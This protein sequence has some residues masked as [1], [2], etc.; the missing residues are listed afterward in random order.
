MIPTVE[1]ETEYVWRTIR[2]I[3]FFEE[4]NYPVSL[5]P[6]E[7][8]ESLKEKSKAGTFGEED[9][10]ELFRYMNAKVYNEK[11]YQ[12]GKKKIE[13]QKDLV[14]KMANQIIQSKKKWLQATVTIQSLI[15][16]FTVYKETGNDDIVQECQKY[17][18]KNQANNRLQCPDG[19]TCHV[20]R[21]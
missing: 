4:N 18:C 7:Y 9:Y 20:Q 3:K 17:L 15:D 2:D 10:P 13:E 14:N 16:Q 8:I 11:N 21:R 1:Q 12:E 19:R 5:P 6:G